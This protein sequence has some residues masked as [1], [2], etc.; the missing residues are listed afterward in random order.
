M[1]DSA[2]PLGFPDGPRSDLDRVLAELVEN[3]QKVQATQGRLRSLLR[4]SRIVVEGLELSVVLRRIVEAAI[5]L[6]GARYGAIG[7]V[8]ADGSL[9]QF[10][11]VGMPDDLVKIIGHLPEGHGLLGAV[12]ADQAPIRLEHLSSDPRSSGFPKGHPAMDSF[13]GVPVKVRGEVYGNLYLSDHEEG[14]FSAEDEEL[15]VALAATA[16][17]AID[18]ARL[19]DETVR[20]QRWAAATAEI[21]STLLGD[22]IDDSL[23]L[24]ADRVAELADVDLVLVVVPEQADELHI[25]VARGALAENVRDATFAAAGTLAGRAQESGQPTLSDEEFVSQAD[26]SLVFGP[27]IAIPLT[28]AGASLGVLV[29][30]RLAGRARFTMSD[31][32]MV[33]DFAAHS[34][35]ALELSRSRADQQR[36]AVLEDRGRIARDL[37]D[38]VIQR[39]FAAGLGL[40][41][42]SGHV[43]DPA[44]KLKL[45]DEV[46]ALDAAITEIR[47]AIFT[48]NAQ[49]AGRRPSLR[50]RLIDIVS[51]VSDL[52]ETAPRI[53]FVGPI[54]LMVPGELG[55]TL[56]AVLREGLTNVARHAHAT[57]TTASVVL[58]DRVVSLT[59][60]DDGVGVD[61]AKV[62]SSGLANLASRAAEWGGQFSLTAGAPSGTVLDWRAPI[63]SAEEKAKA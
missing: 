45:D 2:A 33:S 24:V 43:S 57:E 39:L 19:F 50:H 41:H 61:P 31:L 53:S 6:V 17:V 48:L 8:A 30:L 14:G 60:V 55:E 3:A 42:I 47:T 46:T 22:G 1:T 12:I 29:L 26:P 51:E 27:G 20:R 32:E 25:E 59:I 62:R 34:T 16:G 36:L 44:I 10:I 49:D 4:A 28:T 15:L 56:S 23:E 40:Q 9:E 7:I 38:H 37:H 21:S 54:D 11:H 52:F 13:L 58:V 63:D 18:N 5:E 35:V